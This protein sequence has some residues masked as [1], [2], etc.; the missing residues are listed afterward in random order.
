[1]FVCQKCKVK[2][3]DSGMKLFIHYNVL[4]IIGDKKDGD[5][6]SGSGVTRQIR[7][8]EDCRK[9]NS[10]DLDLEENQ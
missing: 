6:L 4:Y 1:M 10:L 2:V 8:C 3:P 7:L 5:I 9:L